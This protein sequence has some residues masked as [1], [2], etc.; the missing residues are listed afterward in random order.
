MRA[1]KNRKLLLISPSGEKYQI[2]F[3]SPCKDGYVLGTSQIEN[4]ESSHLTI[5]H[6]RGTISAHITPQKQS[7]ER[8]YF[9]PFSVKEFAT[10][11][12][13]LLDNKMVF[14][15]SQEQQSEEVIY[16]TRK[17][18]QWFN[19]LTKALL[20]KKIT[21]KE[22]IYILNFKN[23]FAQLPK[24][25]NDLK[26]SPQS[27]IGLCRAKDMLKEQLNNCRSNQFKDIDHTD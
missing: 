5:I 13:S 20:Q 2:G 25:V 7:K 9:I 27:F 19:A 6:K 16:F 8:Q 3:L 11:V 1:K 23:L 24:L 22:I 4:G 10:R 17:F 12:Q 15:L 21:K 14:Q 18:E 26:T